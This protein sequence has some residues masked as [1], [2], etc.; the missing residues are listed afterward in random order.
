MSV[1]APVVTRPLVSVSVPPTVGL[2]FSVSPLVLLTVRP[3]I[4]VTLL[5]RF[6]PDELPPKTSVEEEVVVRFAAVPAMAAPFS[7]SVFAPTA[8][9][10]LVSVRPLVIATEP[11]RLTPLALLMMTPPLP[12]N[13]DGN[14]TPVVC[15][16]APLYCR[17]APAPYVG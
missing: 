7:V 4:A 9:V 14:S 16:L 5:G 3:L 10:P 12:P 13:V 6:T 17:V 2:L 8:N 15:A 11:P 1:F